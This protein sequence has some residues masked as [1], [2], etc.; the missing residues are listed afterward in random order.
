MYSIFDPVVVE[1]II[2]LIQDQIT[3]VH[4][5]ADQSIKIPLVKVSFY[6]LTSGWLDSNVFSIL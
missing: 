3:A 5:K 1:T 6:S 4:E 2:P